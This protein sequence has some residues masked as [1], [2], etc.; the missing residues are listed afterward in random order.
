MKVKELMHLLVVTV[1]QALTEL[2]Y[3]EQ[4]YVT[5][6][7]LILVVMRVLIADW[8]RYNPRKLC[9]HR[10]VRVL[11]NQLKNSEW[12]RLTQHAHRP[13]FDL[14]NMLH[15]FIKIVPPNIADLH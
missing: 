14:S 4:I 12:L 10:H 5:A 8:A 2:D 15:L 1:T 7:S 3:F 9:V 13:F 6:E 11:L